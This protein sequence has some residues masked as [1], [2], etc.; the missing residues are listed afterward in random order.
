ME[1][2]YYSKVEQLMM[3]Q[4]MQRNMDMN[5]LV[6]HILG[7]IRNGMEKTKDGYILS[8]P[9]NVVNW[10]YDVFLVIQFYFSAKTSRRFQ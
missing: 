9:C 6:A 1:L 3:E 5:D 2:Y 8:F 10:G 4:N 7:F